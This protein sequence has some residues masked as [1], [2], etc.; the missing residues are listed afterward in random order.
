MDETTQ[1]EVRFDIWCERCKHADTPENKEPCVNCLDE[2]SNIDS[3]KPILF[4]A[5]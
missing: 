1:V 4:E 5:K 3:S 2:P